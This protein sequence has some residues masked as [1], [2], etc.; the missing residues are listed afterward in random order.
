MVTILRW[1][2][3]IWSILVFLFALGVMVAPDPYVVE[4][5]PLGDWIQ[6]GF[7]GLAV[8]GLLLAWRWEGLG[9]AIAIAGVVGSGVA[10]GISRGYWF[11]GLAIPALLV[12]VPGILFLVCWRLS[13]GRR[14]PA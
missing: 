1:V 6:L 12:A 7:Y 10:F 3:R 8:L 14:G 13:R 2:A 11:P 5:V 9:G 4:P